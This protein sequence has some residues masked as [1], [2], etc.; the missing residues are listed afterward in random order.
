MG[1]M[2]S[3]TPA[4]IQDKY[5]STS[6]SSIENLRTSKNKKQ[7]CFVKASFLKGSMT[8]RTT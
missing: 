6:I 8:W 7:I 4:A 1:D 5:I 3:G 2:G